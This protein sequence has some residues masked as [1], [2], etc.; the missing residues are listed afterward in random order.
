MKKNLL[1]TV[2]LIIII[3]S[4][5]LAQSK[6]YS[7]GDNLL[8]VGIGLG[9]PYF[10]AGYSSSLPVN[11]TVSYERGITDV[12]SVGGSLSYAS[13]KYNYNIVGTAYSLKESA[14]SVSLRGS[15]HLNDILSIDKKYDLYG[16]AALGYVIVSVSNSLG[17]AASAASGAGF[18]VFA[19]GKYYFQSNLA[20]YAELGYQSLSVLNAG[21]TF[22]F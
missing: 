18:G 9:S 11:P 1:L 2:L 13:S 10:G 22:K 19:G 8:N 3:C 15:Y 21:I 14:T 17:Y 12:I 16:G 5:G 20:I 7:Q 6:S 4:V